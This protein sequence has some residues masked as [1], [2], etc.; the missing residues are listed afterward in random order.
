[1]YC[2]ACAHDALL[3]SELRRMGEDAVVYPLYTPLKLDGEFDFPQR[4]IHLGGVKAYLQHKSRFFRSIPEKW[5][6]WLDNEKLLRWASKF[7][8][9]TKPAELGPM[10]LDTL[11]G[12]LGPMSKEFE[13]LADA[14]ALEEPDI[15]TITNSMLSGVAPLLKVKA[16]TPIVCFL[17][18]ED[19]FLEA[20]PL[21]YKEACIE[22]IRKNSACIDLFIAP[23]V[24]HQEKMVDLLACDPGKVRVVRTG[25]DPNALL[26]EPKQKG[27]SFTVGYLS[28]ILP[29]KGLDLLIEAA[30]GIDTRLLVAGKVLDRKYFQSLDKRQFEFIGELSYG[31]KAGFYNRIDVFCL[32]SR[33]RES[34]GIAVLEALANGVPA[35]VPDKGVFKEIHALTGS[36]AL[37]EP[38]SVESLRSVLTRIHDH[39][40]WLNSLRSSARE[41]IR[42]H[43]NAKTMAEETLK[44]LRAIARPQE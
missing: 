1:M 44:L 42:M 4:E 30:Q 32:P 16:A 34:R 36:V 6:G 29:G 22:Q 18:G 12:S 2:G 21:F 40:Q 8:V 17:Q 13:R 37:Y 28:S 26:G 43:Y 14:V 20:L 15:V 5:V 10:T 24:D 27:Q 3:V 7:A 39:P 23:S 38:E 9:S 25:V 35:V 41:G 19:S 33:I 31:A 11:N